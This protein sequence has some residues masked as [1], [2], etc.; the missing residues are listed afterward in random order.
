[1]LWLD[2]AL[3]TVTIG[4]ALIIVSP[5]AR[6][7]SLYA[8]TDLVGSGY[9]LGM[10]GK[11]T[12]RFWGLFVL[13]FAVHSASHFGK[14]HYISGAAWAMMTPVYLVLMVLA[15]RAPRDAKGE[16]EATAEGSEA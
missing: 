4:T 14:E 11:P 1:M 16:T 15:A 7:M 6:W 10:Y 2:I 8:P 12:W 3:V 13:F 9:V 5:L